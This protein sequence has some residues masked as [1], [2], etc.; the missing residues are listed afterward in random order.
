MEVSQSLNKIW[1]SI[2]MQSI[3]LIR[4][5]TFINRL[6][7]KKNIFQSST[8]TFRNTFRFVYHKKEE[9]GKSVWCSV[10]MVSFKKSS[11][12]YKSNRTKNLFTSFFLEK[13]ETN[14]VI[15]CNVFISRLWIYFW[16]L[17]QVDK[18]MRKTKVFNNNITFDCNF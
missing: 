11:S 4:E 17:K 14:S 18:K 16:L 1:V 10:P 6:S 3:P 5:F 8:P 9:E 15:F 13:Q 12:F 2:C 7:R